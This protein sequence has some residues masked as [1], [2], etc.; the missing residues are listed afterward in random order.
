[1]GLLRF[2]ATGAIRAIVPNLKT[3]KALGAAVRARARRRDNRMNG[4]MSALCQ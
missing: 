3:A 4:E 1:M 2:A